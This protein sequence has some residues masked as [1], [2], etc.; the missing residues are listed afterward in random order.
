MNN[1]KKKERKKAQGTRHKKGTSYKVQGAVEG[2][3][4][5]AGLLKLF[6]FDFRIPS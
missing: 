1:H 3:A 4:S 6:V 5:E 2:Q